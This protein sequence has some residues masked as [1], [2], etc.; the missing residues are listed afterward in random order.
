VGLLWLSFGLTVVVSHML[1]V[2]ALFRGK[3]AEGGQEPSDT[4]YV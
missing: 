4:E 2:Y 1:F 3:V